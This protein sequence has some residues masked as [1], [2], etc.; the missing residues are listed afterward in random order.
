M[1]TVHHASSGG[2]G[3]CVLELTAI[4][5]PTG[6]GALLV[7]VDGLAASAILSSS[8]GDRRPDR[9]MPTLPILLRRGFDATI[10]LVDR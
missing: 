7:P 6:P 8:P 4:I 10:T 9:Q 2:N 1:S 5:V 3:V